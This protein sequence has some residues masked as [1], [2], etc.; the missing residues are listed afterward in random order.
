MKAIK[1]LTLTVLL[2]VLSFTFLTIQMPA[3]E[4]QKN[5]ISSETKWIIHL[6]FK[7]LLKTRLWENIYIKKKTKIRHGEIS[8]LKDLNFDIHKDLNAVSIYG[9][10]KGDMDTDNAVVLLSGNFNTIKILNRLKSEKEAGKSKYGKFEIYNWDGDDYGTFI[11]NNLLVISHSI[12]N[13]RYALDVIS[14]KKENFMKSSLA[15]RMKEVP[16]DAILFALAGDLSSFIN[17]RHSTPMMINKAKMALFLAM[18]KN[19]DMRLSLKLHTESQEAAQNIMQ[20]GNG[21]LALA[22]MNKK[23]LQGTEKLINSINISANGNVVNAKM[24]IPSDF[25]IKNIDMH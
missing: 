19:S 7:A 2:L 24:Y 10:A 6:D 11:N 16:G 3:F 13:M 4:L 21:L 15:S 23:D 18:E 1:K 5:Y 14:G 12:K 17:K 8:L 22:R 25:I 20:I 9:M